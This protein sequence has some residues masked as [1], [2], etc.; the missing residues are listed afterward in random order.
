SATVMGEPT[1]WRPAMQIGFVDGN[2]RYV[3]LGYRAGRAA[4]SAGTDRYQGGFSGRPA[5]PRAARRVLRSGRDYSPGRA[6]VRPEAGLAAG[7]AITREPAPAA[8]SRGAGD[9][10]GAVWQ[11]H[12]SRHGTIRTGGFVGAENTGRSSEI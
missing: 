11:H 6:R 2:A 10:H 3:S 5:S 7:D 4:R 1:I 9:H 12:R 8:R